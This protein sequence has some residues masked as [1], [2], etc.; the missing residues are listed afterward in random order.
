MKIFAERV[1]RMVARRT[2]LVSSLFMCQV[3]FFATSLLMVS[4]LNVKTVMAADIIA[5]EVA[6][7]ADVVALDTDGLKETI[8]D[9]HVKNIH[10]ETIEAN[11]ESF[12]LLKISGY[13]FFSAVGKPKLPAIRKTIAVPENIVSVKAV[14]IESSFTTHPGYRMYPMQ[15][16][17][18]DGEETL[19]FVIDEMVYSQDSY[20]PEDIVEVGN[21]ATWRDL[22]IVTLAIAPVQYN[23]VTSV[24]KVYDHLKVKLEY[25]V[26]EPLSGTTDSKSKVIEPKFDRMYREQILNYDSLDF[27]VGEPDYESMRDEGEILEAS[28]DIVDGERDGIPNDTSIKYLSIRHRDCSEYSTLKPLLDWH[29][30]CGLPCTSI[31]L[32]GTQTPES[33][34]DTISNYYNKYPELEFVLLVGDITCLPWHPNWGG[35]EDDELPG[36]HWFACLT[37]GDNPDLWPE[38]AVGRLPVTDNAELAEVV[39]KIL[40]YSKNAPSGGWVNNALLV[41]HKEAAPGKYQGCKEEIRTATYSDSFNF[42][43][44]YGASIAAG[45]DGA[46]N[47]DLSGAINDGVGIVNYRGHGA[48]GFPSDRPWGTF[49]GA[50]AGAN[51]PAPWN[52][53][54]EEYWTTD[55][56]N[57]ANGSRTPVVFSIS[58]MNNALDNPSND[59]LGEAFVMQ[60]EGAVAFLGAS[61]PSYTTPNHDFDKNLFDALGNEDIHEIGWVLNDANAELLADYGAGSTYMDNLKIYL[62]LGDPAMKVWTQGPF[63]FQSVTYP[64]DVSTGKMTVT[65]GFWILIPNQP[66]RFIATPGALVTIDGCGVYT[67]KKTDSAGEAKFYFVPDNSG[68]MNVTVNKTNYLPHEGVVDIVPLEDAITNISFSPF[69]PE[70][71][72]FDEKVYATFDYTTTDPGGIQIFVRPYTDGART[73]N[74]GAHGS[75]LWPY[76]SGSG[77][78]WFTITSGDTAIDQIQFTIWNHDQSELLLELF[79]PV[80]FTYG[81]SVHNFSIDPPSPETLKWND[82]VNVSFDYF[83]YEDDVRIFVRPYTKGSSSPSYTAHGSPLYPKG[84]GS[85]EGYFTITSGETDV[86]ALKVTLTNSV[87]NVLFETFIPVSYHFEGYPEIEVSPSF[88]DIQLPVGASGVRTLHIDNN[89]FAPLAYGIRDRRVTGA[90]NGDLSAGDAPTDIGALVTSSAPVTRDGLPD[91]GDT[92]PSDGLSLPDTRSTDGDFDGGSLQDL[93]GVT[94]AYDLTHNER[95]PAEL[96]LIKNDLL[97]RGATIVYIEAGP[98]TESLLAPYDILWINEDWL[99]TVPWLAAEQAAVKAFVVS[100]KGLFLYGDEPGAAAVLAELFGITFAAAGASGY[101]SNI[102]SHAITQEVSGLYLINPETSLAVSPPATTIVYDL[103]GAPSIA[104]VEPGDGRVVVMADDYLWGPYMEYADNRLMGNQAFDWLIPT[105]ASWLTESPNAGLLSSGLAGDDVLINFDASGLV[106]GDYFAEVCIANNDQDEAPTIVTVHLTVNRPPGVD[107]NSDGTH[108]IALF[109]PDNHKWYIKDQSTFTYGTSDCLPIPGDYDGDGITDL[110][111]VD[112]T[113]PDGRAKWY[114]DGI[115]VFIYGL[116]EWI[117]VPGDYDGDGIT[118]TALFDPVSGKWYVRDQ[119]VT[120]YGAG[121]IPVPGD[122]NGDGKTDI[123]VFY[124]AINK[125]YIK[126][127]GTYTYGMADCIPV[128]ADYNGDGVTDLAVIDTSRPD[129][130]AKWY[131]RNQAVFIYGAVADTIP[132]PGDYDGDGRADPCLFYQNNGKWYC[133]NIGIWTYGNGSMIPLADNLATRYAISQAA[134]G[135]AVW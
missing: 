20:Y 118:D 29:R 117:P 80:D 46:T 114:L 67:S 62:W 119:F 84:R 14:V 45:G 44:A 83:S 131:I 32:S 68:T 59:C 124:P 55:A 61:R 128:P 9:V 79:A 70:S 19:A 94:I 53:A 132:V 66:P 125:W 57:L 87:S 47:D 33:I 122:Y 101:T 22:H 73:P 50:Q 99:E 78:G 115:G 43:T 17:Q 58:C 23:P 91:G 103:A 39:D 60:D 116:Q 36:D 12:Q 5:G 56:L 97:A 86:D 127:I 110:A 92:D 65:V 98:I 11:G 18:K 51:N 102:S 35:E 134:G 88:F 112:L 27:I 24:L 28:S 71:L 95:N 37:G 111:V 30:Q 105:D 130:M 6:G 123:A 109:N 76:P 4:V 75:G 48:Y 104:C 10:L 74:Y 16:P 15:K 107:F 42:Q 3:L 25:T 2:A 89:G 40:A 49:W 96:E 121:G 135:S 106:A 120:T 69:S 126:D 72:Y 54:G 38:V 1:K 7:Q 8:I 64:S 77:S 113:R 31:A 133:R 90:V 21:L 52:T 100:G 93:T 63:N 13:K 81:Y 129:G 85:G 34:K 82:H 41:A 26:A 108:D